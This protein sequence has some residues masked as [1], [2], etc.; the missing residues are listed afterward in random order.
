M[1]PLQARFLGAEGISACFSDQ[2]L[3]S[4]MLEFEAALALAQAEAGVIDGAAARSIAAACRE[5]RFD[6]DTLGREA[7]VAG[8]LTISFV[9]GLTAQVAARD[10]QAA[11]YVHWGATSQDVV[12]TALALQIKRATQLLRADL[13]RLGDAVARLAHDHQLTPMAGRTLLLQATPISFGWKAATWL[14]QLTRSLE[15][16]DVVAREAARLQFGGASGVLGALGTEGWEVAGALA[17]RLALDLPD[18]SWHG[19][20]DTIARL[21]A[22]LAILTGA[23][24]KIARDVVLLMQS[25]VAEA[26]EPVAG[27]SS[28]MP[29]KRNPVGSVFALEAAQRAPGL[30]ATLMNQL[31]SEHERGFGQW[32][33]QWWTVGELFSAA[34]SAV[35]AMATVCAGLRVDAKAMLAN[36]ERSRGLLFAE[37]LSVALAAKLGKSEA[38]KVTQALCEKAAL[39]GEHLRETA[40]QDAQVRAALP[41]TALNALFEAN[42]ALGSAVEMTDWAIAAW[43]ALR[44]KH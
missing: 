22:E 31:T 11:R 7:R 38:H 43:Q 39:S 29:H 14:T 1:S 44:D 34:G 12:D 21:G 16:L 36:I 28:A 2:A 6:P 19:T 25:E 13:I 15:H 20:R 42:S 4:A 8:T 18:S 3:I 24:G 30:A 5:A 23:A 9:K 35:Q 37:A 10:A 40:G 27:G 33:G 41:G 26:F 32:Q 17:K